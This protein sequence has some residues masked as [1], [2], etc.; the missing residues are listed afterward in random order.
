MREAKVIYWVDIDTLNELEFNPKVRRKD[1]RKLE[2]SI[3]E[4]GFRIDMPILVGNDLR[5]IGDGNRRFTAAKNLGLTEVPVIY[6][7]M[8]AKTLFSLYNRTEVKKPMSGSQWLDAHVNG[9][10]LD[11]APESIQ[12]QIQTIIDFAGWDGVLVFY[13]ENTAPSSFQYVIKA[14]KR[15][16]EQKQ[17]FDMPNDYALKITEWMVIPHKNKLS[18]I[19]ALRTNLENNDPIEYVMNAVARNMPLKKG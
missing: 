1:V 12:K 11:E 16:K 4:L 8:P 7:D 17:D 10:P 6:S 5:T 2:K 15:I 19:R 18:Q 9:L 14:L 13:N 3:D